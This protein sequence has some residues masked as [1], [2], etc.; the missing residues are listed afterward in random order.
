MAEATADPRLRQQ[1]LM[2]ATRA[3]REAQEAPLRLQSLQQ[4]VT[5][6]G[7]Q[8]TAA[9]RAEKTAAANEQADVALAE[10]RAKGT[11]INSQSLAE[12]AKSTGA[13]YNNLLK[14]ELNQLGFNE[15]TAAV[16]MKNLSKEWSR[17][18][19]GGTA[20]INKFLTDKFDPDKNDNVTPELVQTKNGYVVMYGDKVLSNYG[21]HK[22]LNTVIAQV[23]GM[24]NDDPLG[25]LKSLAAIKASDASANYHNA[26]T[27]LT[28]LKADAFKNEQA[29]RT[30][31]SK[32]AADFDALPLDKQNGPEGLALKNKFN[33][34]NAKAGGQISL[35]VQARPGQ[36][37]SDV[38]KAN[39]AEYYKWENDDRNARL[40]QAEKDKKA[41]RMGVY[42]FANPTANTV[43]SGLGSNPYGGSGVASPSAKNQTANT[44]QTPTIPALSSE[45]TR[46]LGP[47]GNAGF[48][49]ELLDG[50]TRTMSPSDLEAMGY[51]FP[52]GTGLQRPWYADLMPRR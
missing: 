38:E 27:G 12:L 20:S 2:E 48:N 28:G 16:E 44:R 10:M 3:E 5:L 25:T 40:P 6:G 47:A 49:V 34:A 30:E 4:G 39:L 46:I 17:A 37:M 9:Q 26:A 45:N 29:G 21:T 19:L 42:Q 24:I 33:M 52:N 7:V 1:M 8:L 50:T 15:K 22:D 41:T 43:Q 14:N 35:G 11:P 51:K 23:H 13:D 36:L 31:A 32:I 18:A